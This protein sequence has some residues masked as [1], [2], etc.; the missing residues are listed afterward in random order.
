MLVGEVGS[1]AGGGGGVGEVGE[2]PVLRDLWTTK[3]RRLQ[4]SGRMLIRARERIITEEISGLERWLEV[5]S[6]AENEECYFGKL[7]Q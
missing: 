7:Q 3:L 1:E 4:G 5:G 6:Q 2:G